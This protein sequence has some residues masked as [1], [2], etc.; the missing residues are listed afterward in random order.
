MREEIN[1][2]GNVSCEELDWGHLHP[3]ELIENWRECMIEWGKD[4]LEDNVLN[5]Y[6]EQGDLIFEYPNITGSWEEYIN[7]IESIKE[8]EDC[9]N[10]LQWSGYCTFTDFLHG[11]LY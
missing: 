4:E 1:M 5:I 3:Q 6:D 11:N 8:I 9:Y 7:G 10:E 2:L